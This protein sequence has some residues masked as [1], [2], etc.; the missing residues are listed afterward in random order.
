MSM[1]KNTPLKSKVVQNTDYDMWK[2]ESQ[3][4]MKPKVVQNI[5]Q[6]APILEKTINKS[7][8]DA[9]KQYSDEHFISVSSMQQFI[10]PQ[11][12]INSSIQS[13]FVHITQW[14]GVD[15]NALTK[16]PTNWKQ[17]HKTA[18][19]WWQRY[20]SNWIGDYFIYPLLS[21]ILH[22]YIINITQQHYQT[23]NQQQMQLIRDR[24]FFYIF[25]EIMDAEVSFR[26]ARKQPVI[27]DQ[28]FTRSKL[29]KEFC[30]AKANKHGEKWD[31]R[32]YQKR[33]SV[34]NAVRDWTLKILAKLS[35]IID[36]N[37]HKES[38]NINF[39]IP[40]INAHH[41]DEKLDVSGVIP[42]GGY[43]TAPSNNI[44][45]GIIP[46]SGNNNTPPH[47]IVIVAPNMVNRYIPPSGYMQYSS[48][49]PQM[50]YSSV[51]SPTFVIRSA[52]LSPHYVY[53][54]NRIHTNNYQSNNMN[55][56]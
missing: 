39:Q 32:R 20:K 56:T 19:N 11:T 53:S 46:H 14:K 5:S 28:S 18:D 12:L 50:S 49:A 15:V 41:H 52:S 17:Y 54:N 44:A 22:E 23:N 3:K 31:I 4:A 29:L 34:R 25:S 43:N 55:Q 16:K 8:K 9:I 10:F 2:N 38:H 37:E 27:L 21:K 13:I 51:H 7:I 33:N 42:H 30:I 45:S 36:V 35:P 40:P 48:S 26:Q 6:R 24:L 1:Q 47:N